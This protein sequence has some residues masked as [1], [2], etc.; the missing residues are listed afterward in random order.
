[1]V[2]VLTLGACGDGRDP[3][4]TMT[5][6][7]I[8]PALGAPTSSAMA[9]TPV[10]GGPLPLLPTATLPPAWAGRPTPTPRCDASGFALA[11]DPVTYPYGAGQVWATE[12]LVVGV[13]EEQRALW[14][15][16]TGDP[17]IVTYS[18]LR[19]T[20]R[21]R[22][23]PIPNLLVRESGGT[24]DGCTQ[25]IG[26]GA[27]PP[28]RSGDRVLLFLRRSETDVEGLP[29]YY[30]AGGYTGLWYVSPDGS[31]ITSATG[32]AQRPLRDMLAEA[33]KAL[34]QSPPQDLN[35]RDVIPLDRAPVGPAPTATP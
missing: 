28:L 3:T 18:R 21:V 20:E 22:G 25:T 8:A 15:L 4:A 2:V 35:P 6:R 16:P 30:I 34:M 23:L 33:R 13:I 17:R 12:Q 14:E 24:L 9:T 1:M 5:N 7:P 10:V 31:T 11:G 29:S 19:V 27:A 32:R 26:G